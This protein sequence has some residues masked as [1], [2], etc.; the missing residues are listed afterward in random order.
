MAQGLQ[1][2]FDAADPRRL[3]EFWALAIGYVTQPPPPEF[4][5]WE[6]W[7]EAMEIPE[8]RWND[9]HAIVDPEGVRPRIFI[10]RVP[11]TKTAKNRMH[12]DVTVS[13]GPGTPIEE[14]RSII[15]AEAE[16]L[17]AAGATAL[18]PMEEHGVYWVVL[19]D[20]EGNE[21]CLH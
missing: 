21:F 4:D 16:R 14:R 1:I 9:S 10:Q 19:Q 11:E 5:S 3:G 15:D 2:V 20:P 8:D 6:E 18:G 7:A 17:V 12:L 13:G